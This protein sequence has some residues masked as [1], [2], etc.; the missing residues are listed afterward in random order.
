MILFVYTKAHLL[1]GCLLCTL[2]VHQGPVTAV[3]FSRGGDFF[4]SGSSDEQMNEYCNG[5]LL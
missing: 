1:E 2:N 5:K 4:S 3:A